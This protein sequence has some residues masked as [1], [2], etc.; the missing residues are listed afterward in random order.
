MSEA[1]TTLTAGSPNSA[2]SKKPGNK[3]L[4]VKSG[5]DSQEVSP[6]RMI[7]VEGLWAARS[8]GQKSAQLG[9]CFG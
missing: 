6:A 5:H 3:L 1:K 9:G 4:L 8:E 7:A 2:A